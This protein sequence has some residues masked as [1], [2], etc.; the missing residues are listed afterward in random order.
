M[1]LED[2]YTKKYI[3]FETKIKDRNNIHKDDFKDYI[4]EDR[5]LSRNYNL[6]DMYRKLRNLLSHE[7]K[8]RNENY[9]MVSQECYNALVRDIEKV[10]NPKTAYEKAVKDVYMVTQDEF[11]SNVIS[12]MLDKNYT[13]TPIVD[14]VGKVIGVF[15]A[16]SLMMYFNKNKKE[17][18]T[19]PFKIKISEIID[20]CK[21]DSDPKVL[22]KFVSRN[23]DEYEISD[24]FK[25]AY[26]NKDRLEMIFITANGKQSEKLLGVLTHWDLL[27]YNKK[28]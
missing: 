16:H 9:I 14:E 18:I 19:E 3:E 12:T 13:C 11:V 4:R 24:M 27:E 1:T 25:D 8:V 7:H 22:Y 17:I 28:D 5:I 23:T 21:F 15:S 6:W 2:E 10:M 26:G 20:F